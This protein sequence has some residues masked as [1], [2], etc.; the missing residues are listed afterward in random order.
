MPSVQPL[1]IRRK[2]KKPK[3]DKKG[4]LVADD[5]ATC[6]LAPDG[7]TSVE[8]SFRMT[9]FQKQKPL[10]GHALLE[11]DLSNVESRES[12]S[13]HSKQLPLCDGLF[14]PV[15]IYNERP[16][17]LNR[18]NIWLWW[19]ML[20]KRW[21]LSCT[22]GASKP[23]IARSISKK[24]KS[25]PEVSE[26]KWEIWNTHSSKFKS[27]DTF[28]VHRLCT[29]NVND[30]GTQEPVT[31]SPDLWSYSRDSFYGEVEKRVA[32]L[33][34]TSEE[35]LKKKKSDIVGKYK[36]KIERYKKKAE[37]KMKKQKKKTK[38]KILKQGDLEKMEQDLDNR[39][40]EI[41]E[42]EEAI[43]R[44]SKE[45]S[46]KLEAVTEMQ[47]LLS[48][49][50]QAIE[51]AD[52]EVEDTDSA[53]QEKVEVISFHITDFDAKLTLASQAVRDAVISDLNEALTNFKNK[54]RKFDRVKISI[55]QAHKVVSSIE[56]QVTVIGESN[57]R[58]EDMDALQETD[59]LLESLRSTLQTAEVHID[60]FEKSCLQTKAYMDNV[61]EIKE[62]VESSQE[63][64]EKNQQL[65][66]EMQEMKS[67]TAEEM[68]VL[69]S[70][71]SQLTDMIR[72]LE[73]Q[74]KET[75]EKSAR[76][77]S[78]VGVLSSESSQWKSK[79][80][81]LQVE[82]TQLN[83]QI[84]ES[85]S[86][87]RS[88]N[89]RHS[90]DLRMI[91]ELQSN[92]KGK[93]NRKEGETTFRNFSA[94]QVCSF[95]MT[96][97]P[98]ANYSVELPRLV[99]SIIQNEVT[100]AL[101]LD[102]VALSGF[103]MEER[104][105]M[106]FDLFPKDSIDEG[107]TKEILKHL[108]SAVKEYE[109]SVSNLVSTPKTRPTIRAAPLNFVSNQSWIN[110]FPN[111]PVLNRASPQPSHTISPRRP[112]PL[113]TSW[114]TRCNF[115]PT[116]RRPNSSTL[117]S[118]CTILPQ[119]PVLN[120]TSTQPSVH[121]DPKSNLPCI[122]STQA[123]IHISPE[124]PTDS[125]TDL[126]ID[127]FLRKEYQSVNQRSSILSPQGAL[128]IQP[129]PPSVDKVGSIHTN[130]TIVRS[131][132]ES[133]QKA[134]EIQ[135]KTFANIEC[136][137]TFTFV[138][139]KVNPPK[140]ESSQNSNVSPI[141]KRKNVESIQ[142]LVSIKPKRVKR[143]VE[144]SVDSKRDCVDIFPKRMKRKRKLEVDSKTTSNDIVEP[145]SKKRKLTEHEVSKEKPRPKLEPKEGGKS[146]GKDVLQKIE[147]K[148]AG[149]KSEEMSV[150]GVDPG[151]KTPIKKLEPKEK[152]SVEK[153]EPEEK[154]SVKHV[155]DQEKTSAKNAAPEDKVSMKI[156]P[157]KETTD[158]RI[159]TEPQ[160][161]LDESKPSKPPSK[162]KVGPK[163]E[164]SEKKIEPEEQ[165][166]VK[167][168]EPKEKISSKKSVPK[169]KV[170]VKKVDQK[171]ETS[172][173]KTDAKP[174]SKMEPKR[175]MSEK[176]IEPQEQGSV[177]K[178]ETKEKT[179]PKK[180]VP[181]AKVSVKKVE[182][183]KETSRQRRDAKPQ[184]KSN[185]I[186]RSKPPP[187]EIDER[188]LR[189]MTVKE[190]KKYLQSN[191]LTLN[192]NAKAVILAKALQ[193]LRERKTKRKSVVRKNLDRGRSVS[194]NGIPAERVVRSSD[195]K[196]RSRNED[197]LRKRRKPNPKKESAP[198]PKSST[199]HFK[200]GKRERHTLQSGV[201]VE[202]S[203]KDSKVKKSSEV[204]QT[205]KSKPETENPSKK[206]YQKRRRR[207]VIG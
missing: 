72:S 201:V 170:S 184:V 139:P 7:K 60:D 21:T 51:K 107:K 161:E 80:V 150:K 38:S 113:E 31:L 92:F 194:L 61:K 153:I 207:V 74:L 45:L 162:S 1:H 154:T 89:Q 167:K 128:H 19:N 33:N 115:A 29:C 196:R 43:D 8:N 146:L 145:Q 55:S 104:I 96:K 117:Q 187:K 97:I 93:L 195:R 23:T 160:A 121:I 86:R 205:K 79:A 59:E 149:P 164:M 83:A 2:L 27:K 101:I 137:Q 20:D 82:I 177:K 127:R 87:I 197:E 48:D 18:R 54:R 169:A 100:G 88:Y 67:K 133:P 44:K 70:K 12:K 73:S 16:A 109:A 166:L 103:H 10:H 138:A 118:T 85:K 102:A 178:L 17:Y 49:K 57:I 58:Q 183:K 111:H 15:I 174:Q 165:G 203:K 71:K 186:K 68:Y 65:E 9:Q 191:G 168:V 11:I 22:L 90:E 66:K 142:K 35:L 110:I 52:E 91:S 95:L 56:S 116:L 39:E 24:G 94:S 185:E 198:S 163:N 190:L 69:E 206:V 3:S 36:G 156:E 188:A 181:K 37:T 84:V 119:I 173:L 130:G 26:V 202:K 158:L 151:K 132:V 122:I 172:R 147:S 81:K 180:S 13:K 5:P 40:E 47:K 157:K 108:A 135:P 64:K 25:S 140:I 152:I 176:K 6:G 28:T 53:K 42:Q 106:I 99:K 32:E 62:R 182:P 148:A 143:H 125:V 134:T 98:S 75:E 159:G 204:Q 193:M 199:K 179:S 77:A 105:S 50:I 30:G 63:Y 34:R 131:N 126:D 144:I 189:G 4:L 120:T 200:T 78:E 114:Q 124:S 192:T 155:G 46:E 112:R 41:K 175:E 141:R 123:Q 136:P 129:E 76:F 171:K 14:R